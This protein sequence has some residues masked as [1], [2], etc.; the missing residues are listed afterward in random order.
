MSRQPN[1]R[2]SRA[3]HRTV[4]PAFRPLAVGALLLQAGPT[5]CV[6]GT[7]RANVARPCETLADCP[8]HDDPCLHP[9]SCINRNCIYRAPDACSAYAA[10][11]TAPSPDAPDGSP[12][13]TDLPA[14]SATRDVLSPD[15]SDLTG[16]SADADAGGDVTHDAPADGRDAAATMDDGAES[17]DEGA[18]LSDAGDSPTDAADE[19]PGDSDA[20]SDDRG[21]FSDAADSAA[22][23]DAAGDATTDASDQAPDDGLDA[24]DMSPLADSGGNADDA[25]ATVDVDPDSDPGAAPACLAAANGTPC[26]DGDPCTLGDTCTNGVCIS[27]AP[28]DCDDANPCTTDERCLEGDCVATP[29]GDGLG[30]SACD[31]GMSCREGACV[32]EREDGRRL[33]P[34]PPS[35]PS[36]ALAVTVGPDG[37]WVAG[38]TTSPDRGSDGWIALR[39]TD[40]RWRS[41]ARPGGPGDD[42]IHGVLAMP[43]GTA[44]F[45]GETRQAGR[46]D[47]DL[48]LGRITADGQVPWDVPIGGDAHE[49]GRAI[50][51]SGG[52]LYVAGVKT[53]GDSGTMAWLVRTDAEGRA[54]FRR[55]Y[56]GSGSSFAGLAAAPDGALYAVGEKATEQGDSDLW[57]ARLSVDG[58]L[59]WQRTFGGHDDEFGDFAFML[60]DGDIVAGGESRSNG[61]GQAEAFL[62]RVGPDGSMRWTARHGGE[63]DV[64]LAA[65]AYDARTNSI[66]V[67]GRQRAAGA[68][69]ATPWWSAFTL[70]GDPLDAFT[71]PVDGDGRLLT[72]VVAAEGTVY[73]GGSAANAAIVIAEIPSC[74]D[75]NPCTEDLC[76]DGT[77]SHE[78]KA[79]PCDDGLDCTVDDA[80]EAGACAGSPAPDGTSCRGCGARASCVAGRC[81]DAAADDGSSWHPTTAPGLW[82]AGPIVPSESGVH[83]RL[84]TH[85]EE[86]E[87]LRRAWVVASDAHGDESWRTEVR[88][89]SDDALHA[90][91]PRDGG[92]VATGETAGSAADPADCL[93]AGVSSSGSMLWERR[94]GRAPHDRCFAILLDPR[95]GDTV[96]AGASAPTRDD[97][98]DGLLIVLPADASAP[99]VRTYG[100]VGPDRLAGV[101]PRGS[102]GHY[103][104]GWTTS[105]RGDAD[106]WLQRVDSAG[107]VVWSRTYGGEANDTADGVLADRNGLL[108]FGESRSFDD[109]ASSIWLVRTDLDGN[110]VWTWRWATANDQFA[111]FAAPDPRGGWVLTGRSNP[112]G[113][114]PGDALFARVSPHGQTLWQRTFGGAD[115]DRPGGAVV[116]PDGRLTAA[117]Q[118]GQAEGILVFPADCDDDDPCTLDRC[119]PDLG[120]LYTDDG[121]CAEAPAE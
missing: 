52:S 18:Q 6:D 119:D 83:I 91:A 99:L 88:L 117:V 70:Q 26:E 48:W 14:D 42:R 98:D 49:S 109:G 43:D 33:L 61:T 17:A 94:V 15:I 30:C 95:T 64:F 21:E 80:C 68:A 92:V 79:A 106:F 114:D 67:A 107:G 111:S 57:L 86:P 8:D 50:V 66:R 55:S 108:L 45:C 1:S 96:L 81:P 40:G 97:P 74:R 87:G 102:A 12:S 13:A 11:D 41:A 29:V 53:D 85:R 65:G 7:P 46:D 32:R 38:E 2:I 3:I 69:S 113:P 56:G 110:E 116:A 28:L 120:C 37:L 9:Y 27:G 93:L 16:L 35:E 71:E 58:E 104:A 84:A 51:E 115:E 36:A 47:S 39:S 82:S 20:Q 75:G 78:P 100:G 76:V 89:G 54:S 23:A 31:G 22:A 25:I 60:P 105:G 19:P 4:A 44:Y 112:P 10:V 59:I 90:L 34:L 62:V 101:A 118:R 5:G 63:G 24:A 121:S 73:L 103:L 72:M 77:C